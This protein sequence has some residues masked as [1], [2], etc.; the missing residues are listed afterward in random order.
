[1]EKKTV[2]IQR[3]LLVTWLCVILF[4]AGIFNIIYSFTGVFAAYGLLYSAANVLLIVILFAGLSGVW[5]ME[6][7]GVILFSIVISLK[8][9]LDLILGA[10]HWWQLLLII[11]VIYFWLN[12]KKMV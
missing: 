8:L 10:F 12:Y 5:S 2:D 1:M 7:W 3:P 9:A 11:P 6:K 4:A